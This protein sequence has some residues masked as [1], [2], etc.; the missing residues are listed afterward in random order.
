MAPFVVGVVTF[1][2]PTLVGLLFMGVVLTW[3]CRS[4]DVKGLDMFK[5]AMVTYTNQ[6]VIYSHIRLFT[7]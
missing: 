2:A 6:S 7:Q 1:V 3:S 4:E 5:V